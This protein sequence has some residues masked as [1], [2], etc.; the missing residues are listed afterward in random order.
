MATAMGIMS[1]KNRINVGVARP[2]LAGIK[3]QYYS[4]TAE[5]C[6]GEQSSIDVRKHDKREQSEMLLTAC[7]LL[8]LRRPSTFCVALIFAR[9]RSRSSCSET[10]PRSRR[11]LTVLSA[12]FKISSRRMI[13][14]YFSFDTTISSRVFRLQSNDISIVDCEIIKLSL[15][16]ATKWLASN[17]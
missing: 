3:A 15:G 12:A 7:A 6:R 4:R 10:P 11:S 13:K 8:L 5:L 17:A 16:F 14:S 1:I 9:R 2:P